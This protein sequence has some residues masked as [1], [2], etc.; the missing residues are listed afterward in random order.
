ML[1]RV[2]PAA[3]EGM[4]TQHPDTMSAEE[5]KAFVADTAD[6]VMQLTEAERITLVQSI[7]ADNAA[8]GH[9]M[10]SGWLRFRESLLSG[11][12]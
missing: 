4:P 6:L 12:F 5:R 2:V 8:A 9:K 7:E 11:R 10:S 3:A 1:N